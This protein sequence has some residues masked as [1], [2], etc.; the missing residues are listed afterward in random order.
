MA[1]AGYLKVRRDARPDLQEMTFEADL[2]A[3][4]AAITSCQKAKAW[5]FAT[6]LFLAFCAQSAVHKLS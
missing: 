5:R 1:A 2:I 4:S 3:F 6:F